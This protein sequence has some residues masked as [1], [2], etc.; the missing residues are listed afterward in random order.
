MQQN[1]RIDGTLPASIGRMVQLREFEYANNIIPPGLP[2]KI[3]MHLTKLTS[4]AP[5]VDT[6]EEE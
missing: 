3:R 4:H 1:N 2:R 5:V 6:E